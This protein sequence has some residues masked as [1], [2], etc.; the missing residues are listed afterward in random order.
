MTVLSSG[1]MVEAEPLVPASIP[2]LRT[3]SADAVR[4]AG[5]DML[6]IDTCEGFGTRMIN[7]AEVTTWGSAWPDGS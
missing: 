3:H 2:R 1:S 4:F 6:P 5:K 7:Q